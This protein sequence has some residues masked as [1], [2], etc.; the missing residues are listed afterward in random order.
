MYFYK[1]GFCVNEKDVEEAV[2][3]EV[4]QEEEG[5]KEEDEAEEEEVE[6]NEEEEDQSQPKS[7]NMEAAVLKHKYSTRGHLTIKRKNYCK[8][9]NSFHF[10]TVLLLFFHAHMH[11]SIHV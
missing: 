11:L 5:E 6:D 9:C 2:E 3:E 1:K 7:P 4:E 10:L 8:F